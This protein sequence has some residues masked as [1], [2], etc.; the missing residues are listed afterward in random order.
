M[1]HT[2]T[3]SDDGREVLVDGKHISDLLAAY[4]G[5]TWVEMWD[6]PDLQTR[7]FLRISIGLVLLGLAESDLPC[8]LAYDHVDEFHKRVVLGGFFSR[9]GR[10]SIDPA[11]W[12]RQHRK[13][14]QVVI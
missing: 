13:S 14:F 10:L 11:E 8:G 1:K 7:P 9:D 2:L 6:R 3:R 4:P 5:S 12:I